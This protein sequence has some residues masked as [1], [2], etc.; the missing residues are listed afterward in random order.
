VTDTPI[1]V[2]TPEPVSPVPPPAASPPPPV[3]P[4]T[5]PVSP[6]AASDDKPDVPVEESKTVKP[7]GKLKQGLRKNKKKII[8]VGLV[9]FLVLGGIVGFKLTQEPT[10]V[11]KLAGETYKNCG[12]LRKWQC[13]GCSSQST[14]TQGYKCKWVSQKCKAVR[15]NT[16]RKSGPPPPPGFG[17][18]SGGCSAGI[19][20]P[21][22]VVIH[23]W[24]PDGKYDRCSDAPKYN[25]VRLAWQVKSSRFKKNC[26]TEQI[27]IVG[28]Y[29]YPEG[30]GSLTCNRWKVRQRPPCSQPLVSPSPSP[31]ASPSPSPS[32]SPSPSPS[33]SPSLECVDLTSTPSASLIELDYLVKFTCE[34]SFSSIAA[35]VAYFRYSV[36]GGTYTTSAAVVIDTVSNV[37]SYD[38]TVDEYGDWE[39]QCR[40]CED[41]TTT[42]SCTEWGEAN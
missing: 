2:D 30:G 22:C 32:A 15:N 37:A 11:E 18:N 23:Y 42:S 31:S 5:P 14:T 4:V 28:T 13:K 39:V 12:S 29:T 26:G 25:G 38:I 1:G 27:D 34:G 21:G 20:W 36:D 9:L 41:D 17:C 7:K 33:P 8:G 10:S 35:P 40:V 6:P 16:C 3:P 24:C 19:T